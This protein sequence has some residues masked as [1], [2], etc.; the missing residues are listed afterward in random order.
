MVV[1]ERTQLQK[2]I[3]SFP[4]C[5]TSDQYAQGQLILV[6]DLRVGNI[7][8]AQDYLGHWNLAIVIDEN[9]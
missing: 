8:D 2:D 9:G 4:E 5:I 1:D 3:A 7:L 6:E